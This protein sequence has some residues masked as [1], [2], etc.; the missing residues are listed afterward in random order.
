[1]DFVYVVPRGEVFPDSYPHGLLPFEEAGAAAGT[2]GTPSGDGDGPGRRARFERAVAERGFF[3]ER[4]HAER[5]P[6]LKQPIPYAVVLVGERVLLLR[7]TRRGGEARLHDKLSIG[8]GG[9]V[10]PIDLAPDAPD[11]TQLLHAAA[12]R[13]LEEE[14]RLDGPVAIE[15]VGILNDD[16]NPVGAVHV[17]YVLRVRV[18]GSVEVRERDLLEGR[19]VTPAELRKLLADGADFETW[20]GLLVRH[21]DLLVSNPP[22][23]LLSSSPVRPPA[24]DTPQTSHAKVRSSAVR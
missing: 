4:A 14:L 19:L 11:R 22:S 13:E 23:T 6:E 20:S 18:S 2:P 5:S 21:L 15:A 3:V 17:G 1:M 9:H 10:E 24:L 7:R 8:V 12:R 16:S